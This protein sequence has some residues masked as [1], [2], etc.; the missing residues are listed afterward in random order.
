M[1][2][3]P[4]TL[5]K[6]LYLSILL[7][8]LNPSSKPFLPSS[9]KIKEIIKF[10]EVLFWQHLAGICAKKEMREKERKNKEL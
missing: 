8:V 5:Q 10:I 1:Q 2:R 4:N 7:L 6:A 3:H 9:T